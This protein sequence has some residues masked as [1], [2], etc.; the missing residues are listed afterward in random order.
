ME[1]LSQLPSFGNLAYTIAAFVIALS[2]IVAI[3]EFGHY[4]VARW[5]GIYSEV[6]SIG[7]GPVLFS[8]EDSR[9]TKWQIAAIPLGGFVKF[10]GDASA[11][12]DKAS[13]DFDELDEAT[14]R[15]T[16][17]GAPL[18]ARAA[19]VAAGPVFNFILTI[20]L[21]TG[22]QLSLGKVIEPPTVQSVHPMPGPATGLQ[23]GDVLLAIEG[24]EVDGFEAIGNA[25]DTLPYRSPLR[26][27]VERD[28]EIL[29]VDGPFPFPPRVSGLEVRS[30]A[31]AAG[32]EV[33]DVIT[34]IN[35]API[36]AFEQ[37]RQIVIA[38]EG[39]ALD[40]DVWRAG[41]ILP[42]TLAPRVRDYPDG[43]GGF[44]TKYMIGIAGSPVIEWQSER[45]GF[46]AALGNGAAQVPALIKQS[47]SGLYHIA[48]GKIGTCNLNGAIT[49]AQGSAVAA[50]QGIITFVSFLA[51]IST[52]IGLINLFPI[53]VLDGGHLVFHAYEALT[54]RP[55]SDGALKVLMGIGLMLLMAL[56]A[57]AL[58]ND[59]VCP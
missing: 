53:P 51:V 37:L 43:K 52:A 55:P 25:I 36:V 15:R 5:C 57:F 22:I 42:V 21:F 48:T 59:I 34:A 30:A 13:E 10:L 46:L 56:M 39:A 17:H 9:G 16:M 28:G 41:E 7:F 50:S 12:S 8:R 32:L 33:G 49:I 40:L 29:D 3:H 31:V 20:V 26:Y 14:K 19:T 58:T 47:L 2:I 35:G 1:I 4:I 23:D 45:L 11:A 44:E 6:F 18:W 54:G 38:S 27:R 24:Q